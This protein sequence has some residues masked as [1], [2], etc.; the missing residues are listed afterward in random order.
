MQKNF[1]TAK[2]NN[3]LAIIQ[4]HSGVESKLNS[5]LEV[6][7]ICKH[8]EEEV[9]EMVVVVIYRYKEV[10]ETVMEVEVT[11]THMG[12]VVMEMVGE[13]ICRHME[14]VGI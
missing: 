12:E 3:Y 6:G 8:T 14:E 13:A 2:V 4:T 7:V 5:L 10:E 11:C 1:V 9:M